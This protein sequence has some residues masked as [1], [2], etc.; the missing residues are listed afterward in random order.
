MK[1]EIEIWSKKEYEENQTSC[2]SENLRC[3]FLICMILVFIDLNQILSFLFLSGHDDY[4]L[5][6]HTE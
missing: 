1:W 4:M 6:Q 3:L 2:W 5:T